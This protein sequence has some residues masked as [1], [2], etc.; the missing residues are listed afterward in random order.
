MTDASS[1]TTN[2]RQTHTHN[3][4]PSYGSSSN[5]VH[6]F[7]MRVAYDKDVL[8]ICLALNEQKIEYFLPTDDAVVV[9]GESTKVVKKPKLKGSHLRP[10]HQIPSHRTQAQEYQVSLSPIYH[11]YPLQRNPKRNDAL[12]AKCIQ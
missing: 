12:G 6:W 2:P 8:T 11:L 5:D 1:Q 9:N 4:I 10:F 7:P 3:S